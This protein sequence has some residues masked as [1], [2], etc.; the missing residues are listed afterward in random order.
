MIK[1]A[2]KLAAWNDRNFNG[3]IAQGKYDRQLI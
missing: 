1:L 3:T 2:P